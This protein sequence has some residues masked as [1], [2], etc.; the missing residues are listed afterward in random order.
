MDTLM[1]R[2]LGRSY[3]ACPRVARHQK[4]RLTAAVAEYVM[5]NCVLVKLLGAAKTYTLVESIGPA[6]PTSTN[7]GV[8][9]KPWFTTTVELPE[10]TTA[11]P[12]F[13]VV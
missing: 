10:G 13:S 4:S 1:P 3:Q 12:L 5:V 2:M 6:N 8:S 11:N 9:S 7:V